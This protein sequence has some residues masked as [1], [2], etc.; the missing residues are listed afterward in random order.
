V[1]WTVLKQSRA[2]PDDEWD[3]AVDRMRSRGFVGPDD[4][5]QLTDAGRVH[6]QWVE[7]RTDAL[8]VPAY[9]ALGEDGCARLRQLVRP[10]S[11]AVIAAG[12][13][14]PALARGRFAADE[15]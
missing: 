9:D 10:L 15:E 3:E 1:K 11:Q 2:W 13:L 6:R 12:L 4:D 8:S 7:D 14:P 5:L